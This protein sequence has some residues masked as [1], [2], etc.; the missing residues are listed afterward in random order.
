M[1]GIVDMTFL[2]RL[3]SRLCDIR[4]GMCMLGQTCSLFIVGVLLVSKRSIFY[5]L[6]YTQFIIWVNLIL[7]GYEGSCMVCK[8]K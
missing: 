2:S 4:F 7:H 3:H 6:L 8:T 1:V 5:G